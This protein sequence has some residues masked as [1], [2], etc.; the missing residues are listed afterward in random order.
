MTSASNSG[1]KTHD[2][3]VNAAAGAAQ[4]AIT[5]T[6][7]QATVRATEIALY[8]TIVTSA[9]ANGVSP[10]SAIRALQ[11]LGVTGL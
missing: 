4:S 1:K 6:T 2:D 3:T 5:A 7:P 8:R 11:S 10:S 9:L